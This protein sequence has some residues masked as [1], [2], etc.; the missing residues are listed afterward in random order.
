MGV[1]GK[2]VAGVEG[3]RDWKFG[4]EGFTGDGKRRDVWVYGGEDRLALIP[5]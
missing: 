1:I 4:W 2:E 5:M 3:K